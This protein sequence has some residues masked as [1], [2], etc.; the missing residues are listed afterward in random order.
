MLN[1]TMRVSWRRRVIPSTTNRKHLASKGR[2]QYFAPLAGV[3]GDNLARAAARTTANE[4]E[5][6]EHKAGSG[7]QLMSAAARFSGLALNTRVIETQLRFVYLF[8]A[9]FRSGF[10]KGLLSRG[11]RLGEDSCAQWTRGCGVWASS[12]LLSLEKD[13]W[14]FLR[15]VFIKVIFT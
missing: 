9:W 6:E 12:C 15:C 13:G 5:A 1:A 7:P 14:R 3:K 10:F 8:S 4:S 2:S 11:F